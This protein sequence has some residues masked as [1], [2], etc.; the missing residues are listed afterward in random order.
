VTKFSNIFASW[1]PRQVVEW[2]LNLSFKAIYALII[3]ELI[4]PNFSYYG[5]S[6][7]L[8]VNRLK[9]TVNRCNIQK[10]H[11]YHKRVSVFLLCIII[12]ASG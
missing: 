6:S 4:L 10:L 8:N 7:I 2:R 12:T 9:P 3:M 5:T 1:Q 11:F